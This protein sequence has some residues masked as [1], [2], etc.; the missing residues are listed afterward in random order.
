M[1]TWAAKLVI[2]SIVRFSCTCSTCLLL[3]EHLRQEEDVRSEL[4][5]QHHLLQV[6][7]WMKVKGGRR[8]NA[9]GGGADWCAEKD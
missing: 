7:K 3:G 5:K 9:G 6:R 8:T 4:M 2:N 1:R